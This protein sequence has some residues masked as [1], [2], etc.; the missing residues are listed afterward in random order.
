METELN[1][2]NIQVTGLFTL[3]TS[4]GADGNVITS[5]STF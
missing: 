4:F 2:Q 5:D 3:G 1:N